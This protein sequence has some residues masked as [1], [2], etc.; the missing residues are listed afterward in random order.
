V[1]TEERLLARELR[2][3]GRSIKE[4]EQQLLVSRSSVSLWV[5]DV[6]LG[7]EQRARL[8]EKAR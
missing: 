5:R 6:E 3:A 8:I 2:A 7:P 4:I 1:K